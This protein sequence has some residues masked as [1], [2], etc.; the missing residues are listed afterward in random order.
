MVSNGSADGKAT[1]G[2]LWRDFG[3]SLRQFVA[4]RVN[5]AD[6]VDEIVQETFLRLHAKIDDIDDPARWI[7][8]VARNSI[9][10]F[11]RSAPRR[12]EVPSDPAVTIDLL[13][14]LDDATNDDDVWQEFVACVDP[15]LSGLSDA[16]REAVSLVDMQ[17]HSQTEVAGELG[18]S[19]SGMKSRVQRAR[20]KMLSALEECCEIEIDARGRPIG[21]TRRPDG[22]SPC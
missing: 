3:A 9:I 8:R 11:Y 14:E 10:D 17:G 22:E 5:N 21:M 2:D 19:V 15:L 20:R 1:A 6:D 4:R 16:D 13:P 7:Y 12:R 18:L